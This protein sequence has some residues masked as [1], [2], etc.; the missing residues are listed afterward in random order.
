MGPRDW[1]RGQRVRVIEWRP[2]RGKPTTGERFRA[3][4]TKGSGCWMWTGGVSEWGGGRFRPGG[5]KRT[6]GPLVNADVVSW[7]LVNGPLPTWQMQGFEGKDIPMGLKHTCG[8]ALC[9]RPDHMET[10]LI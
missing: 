7:E 10:V 3:K 8:V 9:V 6:D 5:S 4:V 2:M 1:I